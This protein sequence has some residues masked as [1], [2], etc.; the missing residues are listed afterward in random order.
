MRIGP[1]IAGFGAGAKTL[2]GINA[3]EDAQNDAARQREKQ[4]AALLEDRLAQKQ[5]RDLQ[6][7][8]LEDEINRPAPEQSWERI[9]TD[10][11]FMQVNPKTGEV[12]P[13]KLE[14]RVL[15]PRAKETSPPPV[16]WQTVQTPKGYAQVNPQTGETRDL[17]IQGPPK[18]PKSPPRPTEKA[19][20]AQ[21]ML[22]GAERAERTL[23]NYSAS[24]RTWVNK[25]PG[26]GNYGQTE[27]DQIAL[28]AAETMHDAYLRLT[29]G[30]TISPEE[31]RRAALQYVPQP[32]DTPGMLRAKATRRRE[33]ISAMRQ[34]AGQTVAVE[35]ED[36]LE[37]G[38]PHP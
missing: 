36:D 35:A 17:G 7:R 18:V 14:D 16:N 21:F 5:M 23:R 37:A 31:L 32:G 30:A 27:K 4:E 29:T 2:R 34:L 10:H 24:P 13:I 1:L 3:Q 11:G 6:M 9:E 38:L 28:Q 15:M 19:S 22:P 26:L 20:L 12:R 8:K 25:V 33:I